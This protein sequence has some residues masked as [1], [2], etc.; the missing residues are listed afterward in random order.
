MSA[1]EPV[2]PLGSTGGPGRFM[3]GAEKTSRTFDRRHCDTAVGALTTFGKSSTGR[4]EAD[5][6]TCGGSRPASA[7][8][9]PPSN[10]VLL[11]SPQRSPRLPRMSRTYPDGASGCGTLQPRHS[12]FLRTSRPRVHCRRAT[13]ARSANGHARLRWST[14]DL[15]I[16][17]RSVN[18]SP[19][20]SKSS[21]SVL[22][23]GTYRNEAASVV[24]LCAM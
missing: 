14:L 8:A 19:R 12:D 16:R 20:V 3:S 6:G 24:P 23:R 13:D 11:G 1:P 5:P 9:F 17:V 18:R 10:A 15:L 4:P 7:T 22:R 21:C 2:P